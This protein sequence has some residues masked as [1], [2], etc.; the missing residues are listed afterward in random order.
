LLANYEQQ[1]RKLPY[2]KS[3][4]WRQFFAGVKVASST[5]SEVY[6]YRDVFRERLADATA[7]AAAS[8]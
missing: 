3:F 4:S 6:F 1:L 8:F 5:I 2:R 7:Q